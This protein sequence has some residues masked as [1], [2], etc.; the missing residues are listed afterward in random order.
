ML[1]TVWVSSSVGWVSQFYDTCRVRFSQSNLQKGLVLPKLFFLKK[2]Y[3]RQGYQHFL[4][5]LN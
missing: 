3:V 1:I 4:N 5:K 2:I